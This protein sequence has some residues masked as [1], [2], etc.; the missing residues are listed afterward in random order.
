MPAFQDWRSFIFKTSS[1]DMVRGLKRL[2]RVDPALM[3]KGKKILVHACGIWGRG[4][5]CIAVGESRAG[6]Q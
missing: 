5:L 6:V 2:D 1:V 4:V 3:G